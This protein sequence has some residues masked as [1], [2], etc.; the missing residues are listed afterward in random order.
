MGVKA[1]YNKN[2]IIVGNLNMIGNEGIDFNYQDLIKD[3]EVKG[4]A[5]IIVAYNSKVIGIFGISDKIRDE[6]KNFLYL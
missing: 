6:S 2:T 3:I 1:I 5:F 4:K